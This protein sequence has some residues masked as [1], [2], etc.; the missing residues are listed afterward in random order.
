MTADRVLYSA[1][2][3]ILSAVRVLFPFSQASCRATKYSIQLR[4]HPDGRQST[5]SSRS[6]HPGGRQS[7]LSSRS[8]HPGGRQSTLSGWSKHYGGRQST[9]SGWSKHYDARQSA[10]FERS[11]HCDGRQSALSNCGSIVTAIRVFLPIAQA[12]CRPLECLKM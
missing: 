9:L 2:E 12:F 1:S 6:K 8:K 11:K 4:K 10:L 3:S 7:T 5:L